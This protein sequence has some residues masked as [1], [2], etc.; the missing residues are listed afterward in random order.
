MDADDWFALHSTVCPTAT[1][2]IRTY[3]G[4]VYLE[5]GTCCAKPPG[6]GEGLDSE[7]DADTRPLPQP[8]QGYSYDVPS[9]FPAALEPQSKPESQKEKPNR[10]KRR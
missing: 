9:R 3:E 10:Y 6:P 1:V 2:R 7:G 8:R 4:R 5:C